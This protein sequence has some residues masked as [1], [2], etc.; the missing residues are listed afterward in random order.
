MRFLKNRYFF[1][2]PLTDTDLVTLGLTP[3][4]NSPLFT[5]SFA[6]SGQRLSLRD[7]D[8]NGSVSLPVVSRQFP[9]DNR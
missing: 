9:R 2:P 4:A 8:C 7:K 3:L 5:H 1:V 6:L